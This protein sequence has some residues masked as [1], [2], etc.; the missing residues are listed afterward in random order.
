MPKT[1]A[2]RSGSRH[3]DYCICRD[4]EAHMAGLLGV[5]S[6]EAREHLRNARIEVL[7][8]IRSVIDSRIEH[9]SRSQQKGKK[10]A[11]E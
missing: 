6:D 7:K 4:I 2:A 11:V 5:R 8:A 1:N 9:L 3:E 10:I